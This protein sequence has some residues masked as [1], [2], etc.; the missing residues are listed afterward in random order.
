MV[1]RCDARRRLIVPGLNQIGVP[2]HLPKGAFFAFPSVAPTGLSAQVFAERRLHE[3]R[4]TVVPG[5]AFG[6]GGE[7]RARRSY[8]TA[9][10]RAKEA[11]GRWTVASAP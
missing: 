6:F 5:D 1:D 8:A 7:G 11:L 10:P 9:P 2:C 3:A 4:V